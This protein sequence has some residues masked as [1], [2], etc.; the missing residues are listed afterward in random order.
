MKVLGRSK[1]YVL[2]T[3]IETGSFEREILLERMDTGIASE[4]AKA[5]QRSK[6]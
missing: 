5:P 1:L 2:S 4:K 3:E 6:G